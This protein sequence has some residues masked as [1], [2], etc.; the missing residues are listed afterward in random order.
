MCIKCHQQIWTPRWSWWFSSV[1]FVSVLGQFLKFFLCTN[2]TSF[3]P[4]AL[5]PQKNTVSHGR[6]LVF[7]TQHKAWFL[8]FWT[9]ISKPTFLLLLLLLLLLFV[10]VVVVV[11]INYFPASKKTLQSHLS[12]TILFKATNFGIQGTQLLLLQWVP[13]H[14]PGSSCSPTC[15]QLWRR[16]APR[17][18]TSKRGWSYG[19]S[20]YSM[21]PWNAP[22]G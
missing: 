14:L 11:I 6:F 22:E 19:A 18:E 4:G 2:R 15:L 13:L 12:P 17:W 20:G 10:V 5:Q 21:V 1:T 16:W 9:H 3:V 7:K 8:G